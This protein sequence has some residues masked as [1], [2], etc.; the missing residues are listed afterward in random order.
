MKA[1]PAA[2]RDE[3]LYMKD[4]AGWRSW[5]RRNHRRKRTI[6]LVF[7]RKHAG[8]QGVAYGEAL[9]EALCFGWIDSLVRRVDDESYLRKFTR[10]NPGSSWS[11][12]NTR[13]VRELVR[14]GRMTR[15]GLATFKPGNITRTLPGPGQAKRLVIPRTVSRDLFAQKLVR[16]RFKTLAPS[17]RRLYIRWILDA[18]KEETRRRRI[19]EVVQVVRTGKKL[20]LK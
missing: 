2:Q 12:R 17:Y 3:V 13:R 20:G 6:W 19:A 11:R 1:H 14:N 8:R 15:A 4:Q 9:D 10:R 18:K 7:Y 16:D 5:L